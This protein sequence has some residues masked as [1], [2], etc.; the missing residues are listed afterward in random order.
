[1]TYNQ[2]ELQLGS[3]FVRRFDPIDSDIIF[4]I[5]AWALIQVELFELLKFIQVPEANLFSLSIDFS[6]WMQNTLVQ[7]I[8]KTLI[9]ILWLVRDSNDWD[10]SI[11]INI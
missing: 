11:A 8:A 7:C 4:L 6:K 2:L 10:T 3:N 5:Q 1:M 9:K